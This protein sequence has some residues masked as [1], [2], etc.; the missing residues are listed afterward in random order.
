MNTRIEFLRDQNHT[1]GH[2]RFLG[3]ESLEGLQN[4]FKDKNI[5]LLHEYFHD[6]YAKVHT[7]LN[8]NGMLAS[9]EMGSALSGLLGDFI[10][11]DKKVYQTTKARDWKAEIFQAI[12]G[13]VH[14]NQE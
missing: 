7:V 2:S 3:L 12:Y 10:D 4:C 1:I 9:K 8:R 5:S 13:G 6:D 11:T 14:Q